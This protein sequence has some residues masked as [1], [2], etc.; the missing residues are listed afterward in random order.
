MGERGTVEAHD[1]MISEF[2]SEE[3]G[4]GSV[5]DR[6]ADCDMLSFQ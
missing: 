5:V 4:K 2:G 3:Q 1:Q 6:N